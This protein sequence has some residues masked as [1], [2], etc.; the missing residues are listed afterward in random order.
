MSYPDTP[1]RIP[2]GLRADAPRP[3]TALSLRFLLPAGCFGAAILIIAAGQEW[4]PDLPGDL[5]MWLTAGILLSMTIYGWCTSRSKGHNP[6]IAPLYLVAALYFFEYGWGALVA[7]YWH[8]LPWEARPAFQK[9]FLGAGVWSN[10][11]AACRLA[12]LGGLGLFVGLNLPN[13]FLSLILPRFRWATSDHKLKATVFILAPTVL[14]ICWLLMW[15]VPT[16]LAFPVEVLKGTTDG[17]LLLGT[18]FCIR[19]RAGERLKWL[20]FILIVYGLRIVTTAQ[21][22]QM[23]PV[24]MP[25]LMLA[26]GY[27]VA[28]RAVPWAWIAMAVPLAVYVL[29]PFSAFYKFTRGATVTTD[30]A[31]SI[32]LR[33]WM[34][35]EAF[36][37]STY[38][39]RLELSLERT[40]VRFC[41]IPFPARFLQ[42]YPSFY[43]FAH[44]Q[45]YLA[46][47]GDLVPRLLWPQKPE[48]N[49]ELNTYSEKVRLIQRD[50]GTSMVF[51]GV[52]E[53]YVN[54]GSAGVFVFS[55]LDGWYLSCL[56]KWLVLDGDYLIGSAVFVPLLLNDF[57]LDGV[58]RV[59]T[60]HFRILPV[61]VVIYFLMSRRARHAR[62]V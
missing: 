9:V 1:Y 61:W 53:Y 43:P 10:L 51:D 3:R 58:F 35:S 52:S 49:R 24:F 5:V 7:Y 13:G 56:Y 37:K 50:S 47:I 4:V 8:F 16:S 6:W 41:G 11:P 45:S 28:R 54:F 21:D 15:K 29:L 46:E 44:G 36:G 62:T 60:L 31:Q 22:G 14:F 27:V 38:Q 30:W 20:I 17:M 57:A 32:Q 25:A 26:S 40:I 55:L 12:I 42:Y 59:M 48:V 18:Y 19:G 33:L 2:A 23:M 34:A 39:T